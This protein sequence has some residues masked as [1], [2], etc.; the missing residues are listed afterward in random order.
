MI[1]EIGYQHRRRHGKIFDLDPLG[2][3]EIIDTND[4]ME[5]RMAGNLRVRNLDDDLIAR[6]KR[7]VARHGRP[8]EAEHRKILRQTLKLGHDNWSTPFVDFCLM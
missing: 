1:S 5:Q 6:L 2:A 4:L 7:R 3:C 8:T